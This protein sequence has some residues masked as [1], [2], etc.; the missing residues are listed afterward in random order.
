MLLRFFRIND[1]YRLLGLLIVLICLSIPFLID[2]APIT[3]T[4]LKSFV[5]GEAV[6]EGKLMYGEVIDSTAPLTAAIF[7][8]IEWISGRSLMV[9]H[10]LALAIL[11][12]QAA[13]FAVLLIENKA[14]NDNTYVPALIFGVLCFFSFDLL[15][16]SPELLASTVLLFALNNLFQEIEF[17]IDRDSIM[18][19]IGVW[20]SIATLLVFSYIIFLFGT[21]LILFLFTRL[22]VRKL[23][24]LLYGFALPHGMLMLWYYVRGEPGSVWQ[25]FYLPNLTISGNSLISIKGLL[26]LGAIPLAYFVFSLFMLNREARFTKYQTQ[27][28]QVMFL[29]LLLCLI[30]VIIT[31]ELTPHS[32]LIMVP[33]LAYFISHYLLLIRRKWIAE[34]MMWIF[35]I[36]MFSMNLLARYDRVEQVRYEPLFVGEV[37]GAGE[38]KRVMALSP[39][40]SIYLQNKMA[41]GF[42]DWKLSEAILENPDYYENLIFMQESLENDPPERIV[43]PKNYMER[44]F[45][46]LPSW[47]A[48]FTR[49]SI[50]Y[51]LKP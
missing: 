17:R 12:F 35:L 6:S 41:C 46:R 19:N 18:L 37:A 5:L 51:S 9:R 40:E 27:L 13:Y 29:W 33:S 24:L 7:G 8:M 21:I 34:S 43:D 1:P 42:L 50:Y 3:L 2:P 44:Y 30:Q 11:F 4:E 32:L 31:R 38:G 45:D 10:I 22:H 15:A 23:L 48:R 36:G 25:Y 49:D 20:L 16:F 47:K 28:F 14:Y 39:D 26:V